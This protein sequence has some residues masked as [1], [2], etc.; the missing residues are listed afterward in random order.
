MVAALVVYFVTE[1]LS[2]STFGNGTTAGELMENQSNMFSKSGEDRDSS[3]EMVTGGAA[4]L[5][6]IGP[7]THAHLV[8]ASWP[9]ESYRQLVGE[10]HVDFAND[11]CQKNSTRMRKL[12][13][14]LYAIE[15]K[16]AD[17]QRQKGRKHHVVSSTKLRFRKKIRVTLF[18]L[19]D[20]HVRHRTVRSVFMVR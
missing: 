6:T 15:S 10:D 4:D 7:D 9:F 8:K 11:H 17:K 19:G 12:G 2:G 3:D 16:F 14:S 20:F 13:K 5:S 1:G 18:P